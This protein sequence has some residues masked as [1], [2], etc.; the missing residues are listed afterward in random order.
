MKVKE[1]ITTWLKR[2]FS[3]KSMGF[4]LAIIACLVAYLVFTNDNAIKCKLLFLD[5][6]LEQG[7]NHSV[8]IFSDCD[9]IDISAMKIIPS[10][11]NNEKQSIKELTLKYYLSEYTYNLPYIDKDS[12][13]IHNNIIPTISYK[14]TSD[15]RIDT[16]ETSA[17]LT[18]NSD[19]ISP[20][21]S[22]SPFLYLKMGN[23]SSF[24]ISTFFSASNMSE[25]VKDTVKVNCYKY[26]FEER[27]GFSYEKGMDHLKTIYLFTKIKD[28]FPNLT[29]VKYQYGK[30]SVCPPQKQQIIKNKSKSWRDILW[31]LILNLSM[32]LT[33]ACVSN[34]IVQTLRKVIWK[35]PFKFEN[36]FF[37]ILLLSATLF[38]VILYTIPEF[39]FTL[40]SCKYAF[41][42]IIFG[43][44]EYIEK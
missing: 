24:K 44:K 30:I 26:K 4:I 31:E 39:H 3:V 29:I 34:V 2:I 22:T 11:V 20:N 6:E 8:A 7:S 37:I 38:G 21:T 43:L 18:Y 25:P 40:H 14:A 12:L 35:K 27:G 19:Y 36:N 1:F 32:A 41:I 23:N 33:F 28:K 17:I 16:N 10:V 15:Y 5:N 9:S 13:Q 42:G